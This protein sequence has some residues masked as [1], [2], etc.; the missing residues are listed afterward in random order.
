M[1]QLIRTSFTDVPLRVRE[2][3]AWKTIVLLNQ[4]ISNKLPLTMLPPRLVF[5][6]QSL[7]KWF[8]S[9]EASEASSYRNARVRS[10]YL[11][12][13]SHMAPA[14]LDVPGS[15]WDY[16]LSVIQECLMVS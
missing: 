13:L 16:I 1:C 4:C 8:D 9:E 2:T 10:Q 3:V 7:R 15:H 5:L 6:M 12:L 14:L 11:K